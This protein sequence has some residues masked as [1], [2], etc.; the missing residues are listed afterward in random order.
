MAAAIQG[1][2]DKGVLARIPRFVLAPLMR[3]ALRAAKRREN[4]IALRELVPTVLY[5]T[6]L[7]RESARVIAALASIRAPLLLLGGDRSH[8][9][10]RTS[11]DALA[12]RLPAAQRVMLHGVGHI[13][14][15]NV[16]RPH[17]VAQHLRVFFGLH[18][19]CTNA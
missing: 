14:A 18:P 8:P 10:L 5:D 13:A 17:E 19:R 11:L 1:T 3:L 4:A 2:A 15:D 7:Q 12:K 16:G 9:A 6:R